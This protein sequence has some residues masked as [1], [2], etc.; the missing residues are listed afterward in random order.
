MILIVSNE[1]DISTDEVCQWLYLKKA[2]YFRINSQDRI[3]I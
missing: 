3:Y 1:M 2:N